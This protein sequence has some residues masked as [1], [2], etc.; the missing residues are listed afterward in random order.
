[1]E[2]GGVIVF[3]GYI[4]PNINRANYFRKIYEI[5][6]CVE[7]KKDRIIVLGDINAKS[8]MWGSPAGGAS[9]GLD[10]ATRMGGCKYN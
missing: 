4:S 5:F 10:G 3:G 6:E 2:V 9:R 8:A 7:G 1:M